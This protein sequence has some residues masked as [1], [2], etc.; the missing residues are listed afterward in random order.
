MTSSNSPSRVHSHNTAGS[1]PP[2]TGSSHDIPPR[3][4]EEEGGGVVIESL[5]ACVYVRE[6]A[7]AHA[8]CVRL[9]GQCAS[10][11]PLI[12]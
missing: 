6:R 9:I 5:R 10:M 11:A 1:L 8:Q 7:R 3:G 4:L 12:G 2:P